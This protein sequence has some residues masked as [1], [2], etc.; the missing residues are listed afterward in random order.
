MLDEER[1][2]GYLSILS[3]SH[4]TPG[5]FDAAVKELET[6]GLKRLVVDLRHNL[7]GI[8]DAAVRIANRFNFSTNQGFALRR[9]C[10]VRHRNLYLAL[11]SA[12][13]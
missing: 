4:R 3:F 9:F 11:F 13:P 1:G 5:E 2:I 6:Q 10:G 12:L 8:L 7:G